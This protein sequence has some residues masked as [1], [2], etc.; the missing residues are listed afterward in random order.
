MVSWPDSCLFPGTSLS[1]VPAISSQF[2]GNMA[3]E[4]VYLKAKAV[5]GSRV[6]SSRE[7]ARSG[8]S[9]KEIYFKNSRLCSHDIS[10]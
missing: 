3:S 8:L 7:G 10:Q 5:S 9:F 4:T 6:T 2:N 1:G